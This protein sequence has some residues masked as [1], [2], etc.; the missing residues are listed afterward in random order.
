MPSAIQQVGVIYD[1]TDLAPGEYDANLCLHT[2]DA[3]QRKV[4][5]P[6]HLSVGANRD[7]IFGASF[8]GGA[9]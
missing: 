4:P 5:I 7:A 2:N 3:R 8:E 1:A 9:P 6:V